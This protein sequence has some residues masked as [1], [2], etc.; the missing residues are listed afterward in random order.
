[1]TYHAYLAFFKCIAT[2]YIKGSRR[3]S[4]AQRYNQNTFRILFAVGLINNRTGHSWTFRDSD[5]PL[6]IQF[7]RKTMKNGWASGIGA[8]LKS[9]RTSRRTE[10]I[11]RL[12]WSVPTR[13]E[14]LGARKGLGE[15]HLDISNTLE[16]LAW[17]SHFSSAMWRQ[18]RL[19]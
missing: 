14:L 5:D 11:S 10:A 17:K 9:L 1:M 6:P 8:H 3:N 13:R 16:T 12:A 7:T 15:K 19:V 4:A 18:M 2:L